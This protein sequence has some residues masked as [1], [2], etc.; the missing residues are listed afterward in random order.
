MSLWGR[1]S[2]NSSI[3]FGLFRRCRVCKSYA[4]TKGVVFHMQRTDGFKKDTVSEQND[5]LEQSQQ[6]K[7]LV[8]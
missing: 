5:T 8:S 7:Q 6:A 1:F 2:L 4:Y 3:H